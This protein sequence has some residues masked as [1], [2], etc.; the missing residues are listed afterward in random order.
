MKIII[1]IPE[2]IYQNAKDDMLC[3]SEII[4]KAIQNGIP[5]E[6]VTGFA[7]RCKE[8]GAKYGR[9]LRQKTDDLDKIRAEIEEMAK[10]EW[11][12]QVGSVSQGLEDALE[13]I[14]KYRGEG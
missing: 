1:D 4:V 11:N 7:D 5:Q 3:G 14:D 6:T 10:E 13:I 2:Q 8:C 12:N 9:L